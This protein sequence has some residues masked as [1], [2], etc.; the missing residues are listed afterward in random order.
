MIKEIKTEK[1]EGLAMLVPDSMTEECSFY[2]NALTY[3]VS[4]VTV[5]ESLPTAYHDGK[6]IVLGKATELTEEQCAGI[7]PKSVRVLGSDFKQTGSTYLTET[8]RGD[9]DQFLRYI[10][11]AYSVNPYEKFKGAKLVHS[12]GDPDTADRIVKEVKLRFEQAQAST[13]TW[14]IIQKLKP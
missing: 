13:G 10:L 12:A 7:M 1:F 11:C 14:L 3:K 8:A 6:W 5:C 9:F 4:G 2:P